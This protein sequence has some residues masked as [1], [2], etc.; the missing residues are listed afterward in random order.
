MWSRPRASSSRCRCRSPWRRGLPS[1]P[2]AEAPAE[3]TPPIVIRWSTANEFENY[4]YHVY[5]GLDAEGPFERLT[6]EAIPGAGTTDLP[7]HYRFED[8]S[9][10]PGVVYYY[11]VESVSMSG[12]RKRFT[13][14]RPFEL[15]P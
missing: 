8:P 12:V 7:Q 4:G 3:D 15:T 6:E 2:P 13:P 11:Y 5:R 9:A 10:E 1:E 14:V